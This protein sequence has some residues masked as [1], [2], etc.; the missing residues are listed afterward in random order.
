MKKLIFGL[1][2]AFFAFGVYAQQI[3][4]AVRPFETSGGLSQDE[5]NAVT[6][7]LISQLVSEGTIRVVDRNSFEAIMAEMKFQMSDWSD[8][9]KVAQ[10]GQA[11]KANSIIQGSVMSLAGQIGI[12]ARILDINT[13]Q[14]ISSST[15]RMKSL[16]EIFDKMPAFVQ[17]MIKKLPAPPKPAT[18]ISLEVSTVVGGTLY[19]Q[20]Q[21]ITTLW[22]NG[23]YTIPIERPGTYAVKMMFGDGGEASSQVTITS[24]GITKLNFYVVGGLGPS[25]GI[26]F[27]DKGNST[28]GWQYLEAAPTDLGRTQWGYYG[29]EGGTGTTVGSGKQNTQRIGSSPAAQLC[30]QYRGGGKSDWFLPSKDELDLMYKN[31]KSKGKGGFGDDWYWS[32]S[33]DA[34]EYGSYDGAWF[35]AFS[36]GY[37]GIYLKNDTSFVRAVRAF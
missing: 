28:G 35:Q 22:D 9:A 4:V 25:G 2:F 19:F 10:L 18:G 15:L 34:P 27:Y 12:T 5:S 13:I 36:D 7:L 31:L 23:T 26:V 20:G 3:T 1:V 37:Q 29:I 33:E 11:L 8:D 21:E 14:F 32:S 30:T 17:E 24:Q 16:D 6:E